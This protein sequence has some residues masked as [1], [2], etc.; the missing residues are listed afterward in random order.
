MLV[1]PEKI[2]I[3]A[4]ELEISLQERQHGREVVR[5]PAPAS[6]HRRTPSAASL[7]RAT[8]SGGTLIAFSKSRRATRI[9]LASSAVVRQTVSIG[10]K[11]V[12]AACPAPGR[13]TARGR[14]C[15]V[16]RPAAPAPPRRLAAY[17]WPGPNRAAHCGAEIADLAQAAL[18]LLE[19]GL[20]R[21]AIS[22]GTAGGSPPARSLWRRLFWPWSWSCV[23]FLVMG[24]D[25]CYLNRSHVIGLR[26]RQILISSR[27]DLPRRVRQDEWGHR[28]A[29]PADR[30]RDPEHTME[31]RLRDRFAGRAVAG[32][33]AAVE[34]DDALGKQRR[35][36]EIVQDRDDGDAARGAALGAPRSRR[37]GGAGRGSRSAR[38]AAAR[39]GRARPRRRRA[40]PGRARNARAAARRPTAW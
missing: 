36:I 16:S 39:P 34:H 6:R 1:G 27:A 28:L 33:A 10:E 2:G 37:A 38:R 14:A 40:E 31:H 9:K 26:H 11:L 25:R 15:E 20:D 32:D 4:T 18:E 23:L 21:P 7:A 3:F 13:P 29:E 17:R 12:D 24:D 35:E 5:R 19:P 8:K 30:V 22:P